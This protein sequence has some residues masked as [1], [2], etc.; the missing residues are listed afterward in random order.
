MN[1]STSHRGPR[2]G[3]SRAVTPEPGA[4]GDGAAAQDSGA[5]RTG[6][7]GFGRPGRAGSAA[8]WLGA[9]AVIGFI[10]FS[11]W[12]PYRRAGDNGFVYDDRLIVEQ[13]PRI[14]SLD[15]IG[16]IVATEYWNDPRYDTAEYRPITLLSYAVERAIWGPAAHHFHL[17]NLWLHGLVS[18]FVGLLAWLC[19]RQV[20]G[21]GRD[22]PRGR[23]SLAVAAAVALGA[24]LFAVHPVH[25]EVV[26]GIVG[27]AELLSTLF[28]LATLCAI[29]LGGRWRI[30]VP[31]LVVLALLSKESGILVIPFAALVAIFGLART[32]TAGGAATEAPTRAQAGG[33][34]RS[35]DTGTPSPGKHA[36]SFA[37]RTGILGTLALVGAGTAAAVILRAL[38]IGLHR[39]TI[40]FTDNPLVGYGA[41]G[42]LAGALDIFWRYLILHLWPHRLVP[43]YSYASIPEQSF[44]SPHVWIALLLLIG[45]TVLAVT[46]LLRDGGTPGIRRLI[47]FS[48]AW[49]VVGIGAVM[50]LLFLIHTILAERIAYLPGIGFFLTLAFL[51]YAA[52]TVRARAVR[53]TLAATIGVLFL[54]S[55]V[56]SVRVSVARTQAWSSNLALF[57]QAAKDQP[58]S[59]RIWTSL[60]AAQ[61]EAGEPD[62]ALASLRTS[63]SIFADNEETRARLLA[64]QIQLENPD[65]IRAAAEY[66][67]ER[68]PEN[69]LGYFAMSDVYAR[70]GDLERSLTEAKIG[71]SKDPTFVPLYISAIRSLQRMGKIEEAVALCRDGIANN[72]GSD[73]LE[74]ALGPMLVQIKQWDE[75][76]D[77]YRRLYSE[78]HRW[79]DANYLAWSL[80]QRH[81]ENPASGGPADQ[82]PD[83]SSEGTATGGPSADLREALTAARVAVDLAPAESR[84]HALDTLAEIQWEIGDR[85]QAIQTME[86]LVAEHPED[87]G[88]AETLQRYRTT[89]Q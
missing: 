14:Q 44:A 83:G 42:R 64:A 27:R 7:G 55:F 86:R 72:P 19:L 40:P 69:H 3:D 13:N 67:R 60:G 28:T 62:A 51:A 22:G 37:E 6:S 63:L 88:Y 79:D 31:F 43:D 50:N 45:L 65:S 84:K 73:R 23:S 87:P 82:H 89:A 53:T 39:P 17:V 36:P 77:H 2:S 8:R 75:A 54:A 48:V 16:D 11:A 10:L 12:L 18:L 81:R 20:R 9:L 15:R 52:F 58:R 41:A 24:A 21:N 85:N 74:R 4:K 57:E 1:Q 71:I 33:A 76:I 38:A 80:L 68:Y 5:G 56:L 25:S 30:A 29:I 61:L 78:L 32:R 59:A 46:Y 26:A 66:L 35:D 49:F 70:E 47:G 34:T